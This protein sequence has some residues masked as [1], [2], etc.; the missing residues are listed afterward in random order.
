MQIKEVSH[1]TVTIMPRED[2]IFSSRV[3]PAAYEL[4]EMTNHLHWF[5]NQQLFAYP[6]MIDR[7]GHDPA[8]GY[9][10]ATVEPE[11]PAKSV[12]A[13]D[14]YMVWP[15][16]HAAFVAHVTI[17]G[18]ISSVRVV[19]HDP[20]PNGD[21]NRP[22]FKRADLV[23]ILSGDPTRHYWIRYI[24]LSKETT[25]MMF[26]TTSMQPVTLASYYG[27]CPRSTVVNVPAWSGSLPEITVLSKFND[28]RASGM[29]AG[30]LPG[31]ELAETQDP[32]VFQKVLFRMLVE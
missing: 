28:I 21:P 26:D 15:T 23:Y 1:P 6:A 2:H 8:V 7:L 19:L 27:Y 20:V 5:P 13:V 17:D 10:I 22:H 16:V 30:F 14:A 32:A 3:L 18:G 11:M 29:I 9:R 24:D 31:G 25:M 12:F 4:L